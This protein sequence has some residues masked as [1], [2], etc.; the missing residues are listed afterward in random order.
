MVLFQP[1]FMQVETI[2][3]AQTVLIVVN[4]LPNGSFI[5]QVGS[6][7]KVYLSRSEDLM[8]LDCDDNQVDDYFKLP[9]N[10]LMLVSDVQRKLVVFRAFQRIDYSVVKSLLF[11]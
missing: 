6:I 8:P 7:I 9:T 4:D 3:F 2:Y 5:K 1:L 10:S 11:Y